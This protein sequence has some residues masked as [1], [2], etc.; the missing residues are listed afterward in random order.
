MKLILIPLLLLPI[1]AFS[2]GRVIGAK[3]DSTYSFTWDMA[4]VVQSTLT[5]DVN[6][7]FVVDT[8]YVM[9]DSTMQVVFSDS[10]T[11]Y[12]NVFI[13][14]S[15]NNILYTNE[16]A[17][18]CVNSCYKELGCAKC[19]KAADCSCYCTYETGS[20]SDKNLAIFKEVSPSVWINSRILNNANPE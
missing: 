8:V 17:T 2:Q 10:T 6:S 20:C 5:V 15:I 9:D 1:L 11:T 18:G 12:S 4:K 19:S 16:R 14:T 3:V 13:F 7:E